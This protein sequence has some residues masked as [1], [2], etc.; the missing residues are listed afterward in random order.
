VFPAG[1]GLTF[2]Y[3]QEHVVPLAVFVVLDLL[4]VG[5]A[6]WL[7]RRSPWPGLFAIPAVLLFGLVSYTGGPSAD[8]PGNLALNAGGLVICAVAMILVAGAWTATLWD[9]PGRLPALLGLLL[10]LLGSAGYFANLVSRFAIVLTGSAPAQ[11]QVEDQAWMASA[12]LQGF[13]GDGGFMTLL[14]VW[15]DLLQVA[16]VALT[17]LAA[18]L[19]VDALRR[20]GHLTPRAA[21]A[22]SGLALVLAGLTVLGAVVATKLPAGAYVAFVLTIPFMTTLL[23]SLLSSTTSRLP[24]SLR[25]RSGVGPGGS[26]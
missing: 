8:D 22:L 16:Y 6:F 9:G 10:L 1:I 4:Y 19:L 2:L 14:L 13:N 18:A 24:L 3:G 26:R 20:A 25:R 12:Y 15:I 23:P 21:N 11:A 17:Y 7:I 5:S